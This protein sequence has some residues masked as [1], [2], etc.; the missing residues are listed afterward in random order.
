MQNIL[1]IFSLTD[2]DFIYIFPS[3]ERYSSL[4]IRHFNRKLSG[5]VV[6]VAKF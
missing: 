2:V 4:H 6:E 3:I 1:I 5:S